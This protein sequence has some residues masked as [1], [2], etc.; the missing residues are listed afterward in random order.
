MAEATGGTRSPLDT[1]LWDA[2]AR[3]TEGIEDGARM[4]PIACPGFTDSHYLREAYGTTAY[5]YFPIKAMD[6]ELATVLIHSAN[7]RAAVDDLELGVVPHA[8]RDRTDVARVR[9]G[10][11]KPRPYALSGSSAQRSG[12]S[13]M[14]RRARARSSSSLMTWS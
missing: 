14:Y 5:G 4:A 6:T 7:E 9:R 2:L 11:G 1:P 3:F 13:S 12:F 10:R 8:A